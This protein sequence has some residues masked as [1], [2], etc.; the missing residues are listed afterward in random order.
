MLLKSKGKHIAFIKLAR[1]NGDE[2]EMNDIKY[3]I[4]WRLEIL[5]NKIYFSIDRNLAEKF[6]GHI[7]INKTEDPNIE[8]KMKDMYNW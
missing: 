4:S 2:P 3:L 1:L 7:N 5:Y 6:V 8:T